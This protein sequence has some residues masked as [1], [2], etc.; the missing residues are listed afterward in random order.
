VDELIATN[1][2]KRAVLSG[3]TEQ[4]FQNYPEIAL[5]ELI[6]NAIIHRNYEETASPV[7]ITWFEDR[8]EVTSPGGPYGAVTIESFGQPGLTDA[9]N[10][11]LA[12]AAK[13]LG[14]VQRFG[15]GIPRAKNA[16]QRNGNPDPE[17]QV[18]P[19]FV[20]VTVRAAP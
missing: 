4:T 14:F 8:V 7:M 18:E 12:T 3:K 6:R 10:P 20:N 19:N 9:R 15:S 5:Q 2:T 1:I 16:L 13:T 17:F 11:G